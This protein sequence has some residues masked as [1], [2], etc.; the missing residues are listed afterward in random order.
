MN[1]LPRIS[2]K[3]LAKKYFLH[4]IAI[5]ICIAL[6]ILQCM[7]PLIIYH[8][9]IDSI[10]D[11]IASVMDLVAASTAT[12]AIISLIPD[13]TGTPIAEQL[14]E[15]SKYFI[16]VLGTLYF[17]KFM[18]PLFGFISPLFIIFGIILL[19]N[20]NE[21]IKKASY[22]LIIISIVFMIMIPASNFV[23][24]RID[25]IFKDSIDEP[26]NSAL[27]I[28]ETMNNTET[29]GKNVWEIITTVAKKVVK[30]VSGA[31]EWAK[32]ALNHFVE[33]VGIILITDCV[34]PVLSMIFLFILAKQMVKSIPS[35][36]Y[37]E[38]NTINL[39]N[40]VI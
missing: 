2:W 40:N 5:I 11:K 32:T 17:E 25:L 36:W 9:T 13:D 20:K 29:E 38:K 18:L 7:N 10:N 16:V 27:A 22:F 23:S 19:I 34:I 12:S 39:A 3:Q 8:F 24:D 4:F 14:A 28:E 37:Q 1:T 26:I 15:L 6:I 31:I 30:N 33:V 35:S 21:R